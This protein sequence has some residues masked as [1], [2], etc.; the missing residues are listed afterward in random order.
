MFQAQEGH[1]VTGCGELAA[2][3]YLQIQEEFLEKYLAN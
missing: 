2:L 1:C 3:E